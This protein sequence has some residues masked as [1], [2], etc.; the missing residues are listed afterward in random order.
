ME[1]GSL[2]GEMLCWPRWKYPAVAM[3]FPPP[4]QKHG[5]IDS[6]FNIYGYN[7][8]FCYKWHLILFVA[9]FC[10]VFVLFCLRSKVFIY[11]VFWNRV[12]LCS[13]D[14]PGT[15][16]LSTHQAI[17]KLKY[18]LAF[19]CQ[20]SLYFWFVFSWIVNNT[21]NI[22]SFFFF[23]SRYQQKEHETHACSAS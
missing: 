21:D 4:W 18:P 7:L 12:S 11:L 13:P 2:A 20:A 16:S 22:P 1:I 23:K 17:L 5:L 19:D 15:L 8:R 3:P 9:L 14:C 6:S 10:L